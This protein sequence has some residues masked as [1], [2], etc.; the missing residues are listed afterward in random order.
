VP[1]LWDI[2]ANVRFLVAAPLLIVAE[3]VVHQRMRLI[4]RQFLDR[5]LIPEEALPRFDGAIASPLGCATRRLPRCFLIAL[6]YLVG[7]LI[8]WR[9]FVALSTTATW[10]AI[11]APGG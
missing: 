2:E 8:V 5:N 10:Y 3:L 11:P 6:V 9:N 1:F 7:V 4:V